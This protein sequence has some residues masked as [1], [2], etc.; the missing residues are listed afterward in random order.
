MGKGKLLVQIVG[1]GLLTGLLLVIAWLAVFWVEFPPASSEALD[2]LQ[3]CLASFVFPVLTIAACCWVLCLQNA[4]RWGWCL[5]VAIL[6]FLLTSYVLCRLLSPHLGGDT[7][8]LLAGYYFSFFE[9]VF[10]VPVTF[11]VS[12]LKK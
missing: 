3:D 12:E 5:I 9:I 11:F 10:L 6:F 4:K 1:R 2:Y 7:L 8:L